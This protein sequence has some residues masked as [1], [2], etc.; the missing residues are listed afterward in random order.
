MASPRII[1]TP[2]RRISADIAAAARTK[3]LNDA[4][5]AMDE[6]SSGISSPT[7]DDKVRRLVGQRAQEQVEY[8][9]EYGLAP[10]QV[11]LEAIGDFGNP[12]AGRVAARSIWESLVADPTFTTKL[13][14]TFTGGAPT[15]IAPFKVSTGAHP[16]APAPMG[17]GRR[18]AVSKITPMRM[19]ENMT[20]SEDR[21]LEIGSRLA[22]RNLPGGVGGA[23]V[24]H[25]EDL[26]QSLLQPWLVFRDMKDGFTDSKTKGFAD[27]LSKMMF[28]NRSS[29][30]NAVGRGGFN[31]GTHEANHAI[32][33]GINPSRGFNLMQLTRPAA[34]A[35]NRKLPGQAGYFQD[36]GTELGNLLFQIKRETEITNPRWR[37]I[38]AT[39]ESSDAWLDEVRKFEPTGRDPVI[40]LPGHRN[41]GQPVHGHEEGMMMLKEVLDAMKPEGLNDARS[42]NFDT[43]STR[44][45]RQALL[46]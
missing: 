39:R 23:S 34:T 6:S 44:S 31:V 37:D 26:N 43:G 7:D 2:P 10:R 17:S 22:H 35:F 4:F 20:G 3:D 15:T 29:D 24:Y 16:D 5:R 9:P 42:L 19:L 12:L 33:D 21:A 45:L 30:P 41:Y 8:A 38:G 25:L 11:A 28:L 27:P 40:D 32:L 18:V 36:N 14:D 46:S 1:R 13:N